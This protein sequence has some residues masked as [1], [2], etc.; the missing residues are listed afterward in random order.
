MTDTINTTQQSE[1]VTTSHQEGVSGTDANNHV[2]ISLQEITTTNQGGIPSEEEAPL[3]ET[4]EWLEGGEFPTEALPSVI[5]DIAESLASVNQID[6]ALP[7]MAAI[8]TLSGA[9]GKSVMVHD[10]SPGWKT[11]CN[12]YVIAGAP[13]SYGKGASGSVTKPLLD[14]SLEFQRRFKTNNM[15]ALMAEEILLTANQ[16]KIKKALLS[17]SNKPAAEEEEEYPSPL[18]VVTARLEE[19]KNLL[20]YQPTYHIGAATGPALEEALY[21]NNDQLFSYSAEAGDMISIALGKFGGSDLDLLLAGYSMDDIASARISRGMKSLKPCLSALWM[22]QPSLLSKL[23]ASKDVLDRGLSARVLSFI[24]SHDEIPKDNGENRSVDAII[25]EAWKNCIT[26][27]L[28]Q[29]DEP[30][31]ILATPEAKEE[32]RNWHNHAV[33]LRNGPFQDIEGELGRW[34]ENAIRIAGVLAVAEGQN[35]IS[36][37]VATQ[38]IQI[39]KWC[40]RHSLTLLSSGRITRMNERKDRLRSLLS[41]GQ[42]TIRTLTKNHGFTKTELQLIASETPEEFL[43]ETLRPSVGRPSEIMKLIL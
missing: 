32:F 18:S 23:Y 14:A 20:K 37:L 22:A 36:G 8:A 38:A 29:R 31:V 24:V 16:K 3:Q 43:I 34:R 25:S 12:L 28:S 19:V 21:R 9:I 1:E 27:T 26:T 6:V 4:P 2:S 40:V 42:V 30:R 15:P 33:E 41:K 11:P 13:K 35:E 17:Q 10:A 5:K 7:A 39:L